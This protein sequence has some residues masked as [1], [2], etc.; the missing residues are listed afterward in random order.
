M[1]NQLVPYGDQ[2]LVDESDP[3]RALGDLA[4]SAIA[5]TNPRTIERLRG[6]LWRAQALRTMTPAVAE[7]ASAA[8]DGARIRTQQRRD[9]VSAGFHVSA[10]SRGGYEVRISGE[11]WID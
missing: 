2:M 10:R 6:A 4:N 7:L 11:V 8:A 1:R 5:Q 9:R 3:N